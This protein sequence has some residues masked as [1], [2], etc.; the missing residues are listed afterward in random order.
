MSTESPVGASEAV[1]QDGTQCF[2]VNKTGRIFYVALEEVA[3]GK[4]K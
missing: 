1:A 2:F 3:G 4:A